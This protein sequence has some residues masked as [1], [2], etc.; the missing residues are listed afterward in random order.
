M[1]SLKSWANFLK[2]PFIAYDNTRRSDYVSANDEHLDYVLTMPPKNKTRADYGE[3]IG[4]GVKLLCVFTASWP[5]NYK[6]QLAD[7]FASLDF[8]S[9]ITAR[10]LPNAT[11]TFKVEEDRK[12]LI[13]TTITWVTTNWGQATKS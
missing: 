12:A 9:T 11:H 10:Y 13:G 5:Y 8:G 7:A 4:R 3:F 2:K 6:G 1:L